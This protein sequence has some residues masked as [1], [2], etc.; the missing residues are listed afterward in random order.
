MFARKWAQLRKRRLMRRFRDRIA[1]SPEDSEAHL[2]FG[3]DA[4]KAGLRMLAVA[5]LKTSYFLGVD[6]GEVECLIDRAMRGLALETLD[7]NTFFRFRALKD[8]ICRMFPASQEKVSVLDVGGGEGG[9]ASF[10]AT[11]NYFL[12]DPGVNGIAADMIPFEGQSF[13]VV[14]ACHVL[15]HV[16]VEEREAFLEGLCRLAKRSVLLLNPFRVSGFDE[17]ER[18]RMHVEITGAWWA[19]EH[20]ECSLPTV[21]FVRNFARVRG[22]SVHVEP[23]GSA[24]LSFAW[25]YVDHFARLAGRTGDLDRLNAFINKNIGMIEHSRRA[26]NAYLVRIDVGRG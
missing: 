2:A 21:D 5:E 10:L 1:A 19:K 26:P 24:A 4:L 11:K 23:N 8:Q 12:A 18:L 7:H 3:R 20:L 25:V 13:D 14:V 9:L 15:E 16:P 6:P 17:E 22:F